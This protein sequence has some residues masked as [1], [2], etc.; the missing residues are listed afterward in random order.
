[1][2]EQIH[3]TRQH[4][5]RIFAEMNSQDTSLCETVL[6]RDGVYCGHRFTCDEF[7]AVWFF[8]E[9][10]IKVYD[11]DRKLLRVE[12]LGHDGEYRRAA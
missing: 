4:V 10:E 5:L 12:T 6:V 1:M 11:H 2:S 9:N 7:T 8:E 3:R